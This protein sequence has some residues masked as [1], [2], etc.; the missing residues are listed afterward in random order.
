MTRRPARP[1]VQWPWILLAAGAVLLSAAGYLMVAAVQ[2]VRDEPTL[3]GGLPEPDGQ[4]EPAGLGQHAAAAIQFSGHTPALLVLLAVMVLAG[5]L[6]LNSLPTAVRISAGGSARP[7]GGIR[8][9]LA[10]LCSATVAGL[11]ALAYAATAAVALTFDSS[12]AQDAPGLWSFIRSTSITALAISLAAL[13][14][15]VPVFLA[16]WVPG[17]S[18]AGAAV[19][20]QQDAAAGPVPGTAGAPHTP[21]SSPPDLIEGPR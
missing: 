9:R 13:V 2:A 3:F 17:P 21:R 1:G 18:P 16:R 12:L 11:L 6:V 8:L 15:L 5:C 7:A 20:N 4:A 10:L 14:L 19:P